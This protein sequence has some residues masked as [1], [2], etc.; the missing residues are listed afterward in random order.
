[1]IDHIRHAWLARQYDEGMALAAGSDLLTLVPLDG[2][3]PE[4][5]VA[6][7]RCTGLVR[8]PSG[9]ITEA[10]RFV[11]GIWFPD[12]YLRQVE[13]FQVLTWLAPRTVWHPNI[14]DRAPLVCVGR[15]IPGTSL[16]AILYQLFEII[17]YQR[18]TMDD[19][20]NHEACAWTRANLARL[21]VDRR[22][23][24]RAVRN[25]VPAPELDFDVVEVSR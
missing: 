2:E 20:L 3:P 17:T 5:Y 22:P 15:L 1:M 6:E 8:Q 9:A 25:E 18:V 12:D 4:R 13:P 21:P 23:L 19:A 14:S 10:D 16:Q 7:F 11:V 24:R